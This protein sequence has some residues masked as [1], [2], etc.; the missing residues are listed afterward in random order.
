[1]AR[2]DGTNASETITPVLVSSSVTADPP[3]S[4]PSDDPDLILGRR[5]HDEL[6][7]GGGND[8]IY[9]GRGFDFLGGDAGEDRLYGGRA[10]T[11]SMAGTTTTSWTAATATIIS[12]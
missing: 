9:G 8:R 3:G 5:G 10:T 2:F 12:S 1:M 4:T 6:D 11:R 7:G